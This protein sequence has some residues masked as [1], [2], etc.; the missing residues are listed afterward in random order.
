[1]L[2]VFAKQ[3]IGAADGVSVALAENGTTR[4]VVA[5]DTF[6]QDADDI[7][8][9]LDEGPCVSALQEHR[10]FVS[11]F[12]PADR[13]WPR[14]GPRVGWIG[15]HS[16]LSLPLL[17]EGRDVGAINIYARSK[18]AFDREAERL[19]AL[20]AA[21]AAVSVA[22]AVVISRAHK[23]AAQMQAAVSSHAVIDQAIGVMISRS[24]ITET[25]A[26]EAL[27][28]LSQREGIKVIDAARRIVATA[29][30]RARERR[31]ESLKPCRAQYRHD[32]R[33]PG[34]HQLPGR[35]AGRSARHR[36]VTITSRFPVVVSRELLAPEAPRGYAGDPHTV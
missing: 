8:Y 34:C 29:Q 11:D 18:Q 22:N 28:L 4:T 5:S 33:R 19:G 17:I 7:Q 26:L 12:L 3:A 16:P 15:I 24:G 31:H 25:E 14:P 21:P 2:A 27:R 30:H 20:F 1:M 13:R 6:V 36:P 10:A 32:H 23:Y 35:V 9:G